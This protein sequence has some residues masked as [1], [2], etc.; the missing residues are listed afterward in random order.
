[1]H[2]LFSLVN[3]HK[4]ADHGGGRKIPRDEE[5]PYPLL[6]FLYNFRRGWNLPLS[7]KNK[8]TSSIIGDPTA[9]VVANYD[10]A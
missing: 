3:L 4:N 6:L 7:Y 1:M 8:I 9:P 10:I 2:R 5:G